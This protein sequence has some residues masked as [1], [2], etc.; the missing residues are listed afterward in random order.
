MIELGRKQALMVVKKTEFGVYL[1]TEDDKVLLP[2][3]Y[4]D[5]DIEE[6]DSMTVFVYRDSKD[7]LIAT[8]LEPLI[9]LGEV[10]PLKV[11]QT[12]QNRRIYGL[13]T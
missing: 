1:G 13:G 10:K 12:Y 5:P 6:G 8:T 11:K 2:A 9:T 3:K 4:A 7:R